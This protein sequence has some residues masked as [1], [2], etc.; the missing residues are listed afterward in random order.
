MKSKALTY[1]P[2][3]KKRIKKHGFRSRK[4]TRA[5]RK[6]LKRRMRKGRKRLVVEY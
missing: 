1:H 6:V 3:N 4:L 5:G 2:S